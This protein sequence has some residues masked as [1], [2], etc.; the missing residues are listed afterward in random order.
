MGQAIQRGSFE[1]RKVVAINLAGD[2]TEHINK[3]DNM[4]TMT[5]KQA[6]KYAA[7]MIVNHWKYSNI[8]RRIP[9]SAVLDEKLFV[10]SNSYK[11][12]V[13]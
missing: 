8:S 6:E 2:I 9:S 11:E 4:E 5:T 1:Q 10:V 13:V 3:L 12:E 7:Q